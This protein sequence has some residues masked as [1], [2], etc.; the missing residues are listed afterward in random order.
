MFEKKLPWIHELNFPQMR[1]RERKR[2]RAAALAHARCF[3][4]FVDVFVNE[5]V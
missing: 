5:R 1:E 4:A 2:E 3:D